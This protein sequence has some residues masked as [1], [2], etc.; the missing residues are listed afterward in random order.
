MFSE[1]TLGR[2]EF[3][4]DEPVSKLLGKW[5]CIIVLTSPSPKIT[6][7]AKLREKLQ[8]LDPPSRGISKTRLGWTTHTTNNH[9]ADL[10]Q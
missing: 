6:A 4:K 3:Y 10:N 9:R 1:L 5:P 8:C 7:Q 2:Y